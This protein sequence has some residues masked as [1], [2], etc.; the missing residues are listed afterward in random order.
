M[1]A[2]CQRQMA[3]GCPYLGRPSPGEWL[4]DCGDAKSE[5][6]TQGAMRHGLELLSKPLSA[7]GLDLLIEGRENPPPPYKAPAIAA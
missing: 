3:R 4:V 5:M 1:A 2:R 6:L 7:K